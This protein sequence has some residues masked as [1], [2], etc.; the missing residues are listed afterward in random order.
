MGL[1]E[2]IVLLVIVGVVLYLV[3]LLPMDP[4][5]RQIMIVLVALFLVIYVCQQMGLLGGDSLR[6]R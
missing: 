4:T 2:L 1:I 6:V 3:G 5:I